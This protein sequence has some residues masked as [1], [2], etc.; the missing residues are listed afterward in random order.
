M[1]HDCC[2]CRLYSGKKRKNKIKR[3]KG[4]YSRIK[5]FTDILKELGK[6]KKKGQVF[7]QAL[8]WR[9]I[10]KRKC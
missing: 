10:M 8:P 4:N 2:S 6:I 5:A 1:H 7:L 3:G 9:P